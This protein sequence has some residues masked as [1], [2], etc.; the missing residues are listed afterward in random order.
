MEKMKKVA[1]R[2]TG[3]LAA[4]S[5][6]DTETECQPTVGQSA[7]TDSSSLSEP[8][9]GSMCISICYGD[10]H[11]PFQPSDKDTL[12]GLQRI[13]EILLLCTWFKQYPSTLACD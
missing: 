10:D 4:D 6:E 1:M 7:S 12:R 2:V 5:Y 13:A 8:P 11:K 3:A 9:P